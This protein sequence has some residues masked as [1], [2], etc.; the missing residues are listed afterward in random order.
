MIQN[1]ILVLFKNKKK[2]KIIKRYYTEKNAKKQFDTLIKKN[3]EIIFEKKIENTAEVVFH[4]GL[5]TNKIKTQNTLVLID[6]LGRNEIAK[7]DDKNYVFIDIKNYNIE[8]K[9]YDYQKKIK[10]TFNEFIKFYCKNTNLKN[11]FSINNKVCVQEDENIFLFS[12]KNIN[13]S[14]RFLNLLESFFFNNN[15]NDSIFVRDVSITQRK[16]IYDML[17]KHGFNKKNLYRQKTTFLKK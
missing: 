9:L 1:Y 2:R 13:E 3:S 5:L 7:L 10:I 16:W 6:D 11:I 15:R 4:L 12:F 8:E 14:N 17:E